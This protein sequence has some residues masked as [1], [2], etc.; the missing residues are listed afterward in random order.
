MV[1][2]VIAF[3]CF[4]LI[5][6]IVLIAV[7]L[8]KNRMVRR[9]ALD[10]L[11]ANKVLVVGSLL[12]IISWALKEVTLEMIDGKISQAEEALAQY[13]MMMHNS[14][15]SMHFL[16]LTEVMFPGNSASSRER[17][18][19]ILEVVIEN[20]YVYAEML[21]QTTRASK[22]VKEGE[23]YFNSTFKRQTDILIKDLI[24]LRKGRNV[25]AIGN[26][27]ATFLPYV[28]EA[29]DTSFV[30]TQ[31]INKLTSYKQLV[32]VVWIVLFALS[33]IL[34]FINNSI[35]ELV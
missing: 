22:E 10:F 28:D 33:A 25:E 8:K 27:I 9:K 24:R 35:K 17:D 34:I 1:V 20:R 19:L 2:F 6:L 18:S 5:S 32:W 14:N 3:A 16:N 21:V 11:Q 7:K 29:L 4:I 15:Q 31:K 12:A 26:V 13:R 23:A 30:G